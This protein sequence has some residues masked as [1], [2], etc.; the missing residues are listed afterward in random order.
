MPAAAEI[1][2]VVLQPTPYCNLDCSY[3]YLPDRDKRQMMAPRTLDAIGRRV[4]ANS[5]A[6]DPVTVVWH[7]GEPMTLPPAWY[8]EA[9]KRL[10][11][12][13]PE[14]RI[15]H[16]F[17]TNAVGLNDSWIDLW[18]RWDVAVGVSL[19]GPADLHDRYRR[20]RSG[21]GSF[22]LTLRGIERL[23]EREYPFHVI[24]VLTAESLRDPERLFDFYLAKNLRNVCFNVE[25]IEGGHRESSLSGL[26]FKQAYQRFL[27]GFAERR[28]KLSSPLH[29]REID[30][31]IQLISAPAE[32]RR[33]NTQIRPLEIVSISVNGGMSTFSPE[34]LGVRDPDFDDF[35]FA[36]VHE[37]G[38]EAIL[39][40]PA[41]L[42]LHSDITEGVEAC[43]KSCAYF[44]VCG[45]GA[46]SNKYFELGTCRGTE[47]L[48]CRLTRQ[49]TLEGVLA[50]YERDAAMA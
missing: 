13:A 16:S 14:R 4:I 29:C 24:S 34:L 23:Q 47:T 22:E 9:F 28:R 1:R 38:P 30:N 32:E 48:H 42:R 49:A 39:R 50:A 7:A 27:T 33:R 12:G 35:I 15:K 18:T 10:A 36:D 31:V 20:T 37:E 25:E 5:I 17:Q 40:N 8:E 43:R 3:C 2:L 11:A 6:R 26:E 44:D 41:F 21:G 19:D 46:P 45:G